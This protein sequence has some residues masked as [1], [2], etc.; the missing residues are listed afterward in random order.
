MNGSQKWRRPTLSSDDGRE[1][2][3]VGASR[4]L[5]LWQHLPRVS[6]DTTT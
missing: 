2:F 6:N 5:N 4:P 1:G 3:L